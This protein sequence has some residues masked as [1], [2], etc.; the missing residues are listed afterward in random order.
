[1]CTFMEFLLSLHACKDTSQG[2]GGNIR[3]LHFIKKGLK[4]SEK[5]LLP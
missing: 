1:M 2:K 4:S 3:G 5:V